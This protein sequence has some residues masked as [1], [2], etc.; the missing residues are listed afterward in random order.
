MPPPGRPGPTS[1]EDPGPG[2]PVARAN[3]APPRTGARPVTEEDRA[4][5]LRAVVTSLSRFLMLWPVCGQ[6]MTPRRRSIDYPG[7]NLLASPMEVLIVLIIFGSFFGTILGFRAM[8]HKETLAELEVQKVK[9]LAEAEARRALLPA[10][11]DLAN[12]LLDAYDEAGQD[13]RS[14]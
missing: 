14:D 9:A 13:L 8:K 7:G 6:A 1:H 12:Q 3:G 2:S 4:L 11:S 5:P 10:R